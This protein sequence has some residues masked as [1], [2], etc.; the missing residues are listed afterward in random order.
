ME[1]VAGRYLPAASSVRWIIE[2]G[3]TMRE[4]RRPIGYWLKRL[5]GLIEENFER[6]LA[7]DGVTR[8]QWQALNT[9]H[10]RPSTQAELAEA[11]QPFL[12]DDLGA[13]GRGDRPARGQG[14][15]RPGEGD[16]LELTR[17]GGWG[18]RRV[19]G[20][21]PGDAAAAGPWGDPRRNTWPRL[22]SSAGW[23]RTWNDPAL[24]GLDRLA[25]PTTGGADR[26]TSRDVGITRP[27]ACPQVRFLFSGTVLDNIR[28]GRPEAT[29]AQVE[30]AA[31]AVG[32]DQ[33]I[34]GLPDGY[35][36]QVGER[37]ALPAAGERQ[38]V[39]FARAWIAD[40]ALLI[41]DEATSNLDAASEA[42]ITDA[43]QRLRSGR[44][45][46]IIAHRLSTVA[47]ADQIAVVEDGRIVESGPPAALRARGGRFAE[48]F[49]R[50]VAGAA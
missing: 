50:W 8:R 47:Q 14:W 9:L 45:T 44:T 18:P 10:Q 42:R 5:D 49:D 37:G 32:A 16:R 39:A 29:R 25:P 36:T 40:P 27:S 23:P 43:L 15:V 46:I 35:D 48:L 11:L 20:A 22:T 38:L 12:V 30:A 31:R 13:D 6:T 4:D 1:G 24:E 41:L 28:F 26:W 33:V 17:A 34:A 2:E 19:A 21:D 7:G 3:G